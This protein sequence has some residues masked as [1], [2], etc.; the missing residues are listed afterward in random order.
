MHCIG[1]R[2]GLVL[3]VLGP[4]FQ[5]A[6]NQD[7]QQWDCN[8]HDKDYH[9]AAKVDDHVVGLIAIVHE[10]WNRFISIPIYLLKNQPQQ[11]T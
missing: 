3:G 6:E 7:N 5:W 11:I 4:V 10:I 8:S 2:L 1:Q 9:Q